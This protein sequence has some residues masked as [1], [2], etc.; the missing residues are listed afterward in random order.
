[1]W[2][3]PRETYKNLKTPDNMPQ[4]LPLAGVRRADKPVFITWSGA[5]TVFGDKIIDE[6]GQ[7]DS[8]LTLKVRKK[9]LHFLKDFLVT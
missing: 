8:K 5:D 7:P 3:T 9:F 2:K 4:Y 6:L 1:V